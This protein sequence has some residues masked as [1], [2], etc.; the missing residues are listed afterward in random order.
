MLIPCAGKEA[1]KLINYVLAG[2][3]LATF[4]QEITWQQITG[5]IKSSYF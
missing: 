3:I 2:C 1:M 5:T 4:I